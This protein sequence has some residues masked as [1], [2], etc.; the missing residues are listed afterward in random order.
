MKHQRKSKVNN[1]KKN[2]TVMA[3]SEQEVKDKLEQL[4]ILLERCGNGASANLATQPNAEVN[5]LLS[6]AVELDK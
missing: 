5:Q 6:H 2:S 3:L 1:K 4:D